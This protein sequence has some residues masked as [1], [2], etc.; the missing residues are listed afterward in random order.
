MQAIHGKKKII[1]YGCAGLGVNMLNIVVGTYLCSALLVGG[2]DQNVEQWTYLNKDLVVAGL[3]AVIVLIAKIIDGVIDIPFANV[4]DNLRT[5]WGNRRPSILVGWIIMIASYLLFLVP[6]TE[7]VSVANTIWFGVLLCVFYGTYTL[8]MLGYYATFAE[9]VDN[10]NDRILLSNVKSI[11]DIVYFVFGFALLPAIV[12]GGLNIRVVALIFL[13]LAFSMFIPLF[14]IKEESTL[15]KEVKKVQTNTIFKSFGRAFA[16]KQFLYWM[17]VC[18][19][20]NFGLQLFLGGI[21]EYFSTTGINMSLVMAASFAP[22]PFTL[23]IYN[24]L[25][26]KKGLGFAYRYVLLMF[27]AGMA[28]MFACQNVPEQF[29]LPIAIFCAILVSFA[30]GAFFSITY[31]VASQ[32]A[33]E[34][35]KKNDGVCSSSMYFAVQGLFE[36]VSAGCATGLMLVY[37]KETDTVQYMTLIVSAACLLAFVMSF[38]LSKSIS[39]LGKQN[40]K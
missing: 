30:I 9:I 13:P 10:E 35:N 6:L 39:M 1:L 34:E 17:L 26:K 21:N 20:M 15:N 27:A 33:S 32:L 18:A 16:N 24:K 40:A 19:V 29:I 8:T 2:F 36:G 14:M 7:G 28:I 23:F 31:T 11:C 12:N 37:L 4:T 3:W 38:F 25:V 5:R 22:A